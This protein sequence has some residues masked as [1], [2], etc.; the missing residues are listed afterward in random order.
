[1]SEPNTAIQEYMAQCQDQV[2]DR[3]SFWLEQHSPVAQTL[4]DAVRYATFNGGKRIRP[5]LVLATA[6][7]L[8]GRAEDAL[9][10]ACAVEMVHSYSLVHDDLPAMDDDE[11]RR[12]KPTCHIAFDEATAILAGDSLQCMA[13]EVIATSSLPTMTAATKVALVR[14]LAESSGTLGMAAGQALDLAAERQQLSQAQ[15]ERIH[16]HKTGRLI[17]ASV[18]MG[19]MVAPKVSDAQLD[20]L[21]TYAD[22]IGLAFQ[23]WDD[24]LDITADTATLGKTQGADEAL[25]KATYPQIMGLREAQAYAHSLHEQALDAI[26]DLGP[27][28]DTLRQLSRFIVSRNH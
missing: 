2:N 15:L 11:L 13:F 27:R 17:Q 8:G 4:S 20:S 25:N 16:R 9:D 28:A 7:A 6:E 26:S 21:S 10:A 19:A 14:C 23:V 5:V 22:A 24:V 18:R 12:G 3:L 1:M